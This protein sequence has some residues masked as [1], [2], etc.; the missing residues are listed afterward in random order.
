VFGDWESLELPDA[1]TADLIL[2]LIEASRFSNIEWK[3]LAITLAKKA[4]QQIDNSYLNACVAQRDCTI[5]RIL[6]DSKH[7][8]LALSKFVVDNRRYELDPRMNAELGQ[9]SLQS[10]MNYI[11]DED[12]TKAIV[13]LRTWR[14]LSVASPS[15]AERIVVYHLD[16][17]QA[18]VLRYQGRISESLKYP[19]RSLLQ[20]KHEHGLK[21]PGLT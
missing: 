2:S 20:S 5:Y 17:R 12:L 8:A 11:Q 10:A 3:H 21:T 7:S 18:K 16:V 6:G 1:A 4:L 14:P 19:Q 9:L 15:T 13:E